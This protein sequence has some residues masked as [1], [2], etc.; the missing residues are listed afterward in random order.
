MVDIGLRVVSGVV[1]LVLLHQMYVPELGGR[2]HRAGGVIAMFWGVV[3][4]VLVAIRGAQQESFSALYITHLVVGGIF[5][6][7]LFAT[8]FLG[9][10]LHQSNQM[11]TT[12]LFLPLG[13]W[14]AAKGTFYALLATL[15][16]GVSSKMLH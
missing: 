15:L 13:H 12:S 3:L 2:R 1:L 7:C 4:M 11:K 16:L 8:G 9:W 5:F 10:K 6:L 14:L